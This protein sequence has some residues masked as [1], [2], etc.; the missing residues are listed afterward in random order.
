MLLTVFIL[1]WGLPAVKQSLNSISAPEYKVA[2]LHNQVSR[3]PPI[4][5]EPTLEKPTKPEEA[6]FKLNWLS[7][8]GSGI[9]IA[10]IVAGFSIGFH[11]AKCY[12]YMLKH[13]GG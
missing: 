7:A 2:Y 9:F 8:T 3:T 10:A 5:P 13:Y 6:V 1:V 4:V 12:A 11:F